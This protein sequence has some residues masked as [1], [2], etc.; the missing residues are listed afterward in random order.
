[1]E[2][3]GEDS[4]P[5]LAA[6]G[7]RVG[8]PSPDSGVRLDLEVELGSMPATFFRAVEETV[9]ETLRQG[10]HGWQVIDCRIVMTRSGYCPRQSHSHVTF[11]KSMSSTA[12]DFRKLTPLVLMSALGTQVYEPVHD[13]GFEAPA[14]TV[15]LLIPALTRLRAVPLTQPDHDPL[16]CGGRA[17]RRTAASLRTGPGHRRRRAWLDR[18]S[19][20]AVPC[21]S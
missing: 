21:R 14:Q 1:M 15:A 3:I 19:R 4:N 13:F 11:D 5:F 12:G 2:A 18:R 10:L 9:T 17:A 6:V 8:P 20:G 16:G 7:L